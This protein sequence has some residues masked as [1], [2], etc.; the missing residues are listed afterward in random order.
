MSFIVKGYFGELVVDHIINGFVF[1]DGRLVVDALLNDETVITIALGKDSIS[2]KEVLSEFNKF[3]SD[4][5]K[6]RKE[7][8]KPKYVW[9][10]WKKDPTLFYNPFTGGRAVAITEVRTNGKRVEVRTETTKASASCNVA[11]GDIFNYDYG[12]VL[13]KNRL[14]AKIV[15]K[16]ANDEKYIK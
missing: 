2:Y 13:A 3:K 12:K 7:P 15:S 10:S 8:E 11:K 6:G 16:R 14:I 1:D 4:D 9:G 5:S